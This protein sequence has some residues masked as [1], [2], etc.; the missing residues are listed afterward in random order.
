MY[1][2]MSHQSVIVHAVLL[3]MFE[4]TAVVWRAF[5]GVSA[6]F[7][8]RTNRILCGVHSNLCSSPPK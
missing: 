5:S 7:G 4:N 1:T 6:Q 3:M 8:F 2:V